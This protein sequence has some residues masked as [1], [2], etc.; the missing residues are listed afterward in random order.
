M[1]SIDLPIR[2]SGPGNLAKGKKIKKNKKLKKRQNK[3]L[4]IS[5]RSSQERKQ[6]ASQEKGTRSTNL[7]PWLWCSLHSPP[8]ATISQAKMPQT[9][10]R[11]SHKLSFWSAGMPCL[12]R[13][14][15][16]SREFVLKMWSG[17]T[18]MVFISLIERC[19]LIYTDVSFSRQPSEQ[20]GLELLGRRWARGVHLRLKPITL[21]LFLL[22]SFI[23][24]SN[25]ECS[26]GEKYLSGFKTQFFLLFSSFFYSI[27]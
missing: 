26:D 8:R 18:V 15:W 11:R 19:V 10:S 12:M 24:P 1:G 4:H 13:K 16:I 2:P 5:P 3:T 27:M 20:P 7:G 14:N 17:L 25:Y 21:P 22:Y 6:R 23:T 9:L